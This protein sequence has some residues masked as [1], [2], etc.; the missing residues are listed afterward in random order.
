MNIFTPFMIVKG[1]GRQ[2]ITG[3]KH[4]ISH[5]R[6]VDAFWSIK[7]FCAF[8]YVR[9]LACDMNQTQN[10]LYCMTINVDTRNVRGVCQRGC[11]SIIARVKTA[12]LLLYHHITTNKG[13]SLM[14]ILITAL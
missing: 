4:E 6:F 12:V 8:L 11:D 10:K 1:R 13:K 7:G 14:Q 9:N 2:V 5:L 3:G